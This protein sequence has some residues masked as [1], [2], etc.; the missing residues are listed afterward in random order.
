[1]PMR[2]RSG[3]TPFRRRS[4]RSSASEPI[5]VRSE[6]LR[7]VRHFR[8]DVLGEEP[9]ENALYGLSVIAR[10]LFEQVFE[11]GGEIRRDRLRQHGPYLRVRGRDLLLVDREES[12]I[13]LLA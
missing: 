3:S 8:G 9:S 4:Q 10:R 6:F 7:P 2:A 11:T 1:M 13:Q 5:R 12:L